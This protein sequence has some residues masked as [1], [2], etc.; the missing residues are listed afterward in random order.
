MRYFR[1]SSKSHEFSNS[2]PMDEKRSVERTLIKKRVKVIT[3]R[4][5]SSYGRLI[6]TPRSNT[7]LPIGFIPGTGY[8]EIPGETEIATCSWEETKSPIKEME[9]HLHTPEI[10]IVVEGEM[11][12]GLSGEER[13]RSRQTHPVA[14]AVEFFMVREGQGIIMRPGLWHAV[15]VPHAVGRSCFFIIF[16]KDT[17]KTDWF[18][19]PF[20]HGKRVW[21]CGC[22]KNLGKE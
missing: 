21:P 13:K 17:A 20:R 8:W 2:P 9:R 4:N 7:N 12:V 3:Q 6:E 5:F 16:A 1:K 11:I 18:M 10:F 19:R 15:F 14:E 22:G